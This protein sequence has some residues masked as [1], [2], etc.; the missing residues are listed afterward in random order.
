[1]RK[2]IFIILILMT[3][4]AIGWGVWATSNPHTWT[5]G[6]VGYWSFDGQNTTSTGTRDM[7]SNDNWGELKNGVGVAGGIVGQALYFDGDD[8]VSVAHNSSLIFGTGDFTIEAWIKGTDTAESYNRIVD[9]SDDELGTGGYIFYIR[10]SDG[11]LRLGLDDTYVSPATPIDVQDGH[12]HHVVVV[13]DRSGNAEFYVDGILDDAVDITGESSFD[14]DST[15][16]LYISK[17]KWAADPMY[18]DG[19]IDEVRIYNRALSAEEVMKHYKQTRRNIQVKAS[20]NN[21][22]VGYWNF[23]EGSGSTAYDVSINSSNGTLTWMAT[24]SN[25]G[26]MNGKQGYALSFDGTDDYVDCGG[27]NSIDSITGDLTLEA[28]VKKTVGGG[29]T[30]VIGNHYGKNDY[31][32]PYNLYIFGSSN[33][34]MFILGEGSDWC[35]GA[36][37]AG[38]AIDE[39]THLVGTIEGTDVKI[40]M[41]GVERGS[42]TFTGTRQTGSKIILGSTALGTSRNFTG[43]IDE[44]RI[45]N[46]ALSATEIERGYRDGLSRLRMVTANPHDWSDGLVGYWNFNGQNTTSSGTRD[47]S[48]EDNWGELKGGIKPIGGIVGQALYFDGTNDYVDCGKDSSLGFGTGTFTM[49]L[50]AKCNPAGGVHQALLSKVDYTNGWIFY[51]YSNN[52]RFAQHSDYTTLATTETYTD[53]IWHHFVAVREDNDDGVLY[54]DGVEKKRAVDFFVGQNLDYDGFLNIGTQNQGAAKYFRG[55]IDEVRIYNRALSAEE[56]MKHYLQTRRNLRL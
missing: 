39:W 36:N 50:W 11:A 14:I 1:M 48:D 32:S 23:N 35:T 29:D 25:G 31:T 47:M 15:E 41:N 51:I 5:N 40:Y 12:W 44:V 38:V 18:F 21:G 3:I 28:W 8:Y 37:V 26:W 43:L 34:A 45:Y 22:L 7:S 4:T 9:K 20:N 2:K 24:S 53:G 10:K 6:L 52:L 27:D 30:T 17:S 16:P 49:E 33:T 19:N 55:P 56:I 46:R 42:D 54:V 13:A